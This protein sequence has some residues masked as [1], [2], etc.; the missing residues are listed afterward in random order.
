VLPQPTKRQRIGDWIN[1][2]C[3]KKERERHL[4]SDRPRPV[5][6]ENETR[7]LNETNKKLTRP[8][9]IQATESAAR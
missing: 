4:S 7:P 6:Y 1:A 8:T 5:C 2:R 9:A 3:L